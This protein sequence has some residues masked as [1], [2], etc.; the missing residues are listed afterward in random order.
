D[1]TKALERLVAESEQRPPQTAAGAGLSMV[2]RQANGEARGQGEGDDSGSRS[3]VSVDETGGVCGKLDALVERVKGLRKRTAEAALFLTVYDLRRAQEEVDKLWAS[4]ELFRR[5]PR[6]SSSVTS[7][8]SF[9]RCDTSYPRQAFAKQAKGFPHQRAQEQ[10]RPGS[11][12]SLRGLTGEEVDVPAEDADE[13]KDFNVADLDRC[14]VT[15][16]HVLGALRLRRLES[17]RVVCGPVRG[18]IYVEACKDC[19]I[20]A[21]GRQLRI[22]DSEDV[23]FYVLVASGPIIEDCS[24][25]RFAPSGLRYPEY[26]YQLQAAGLAKD[27]VTNAWKDV[28]DFKWHR[29]HK[30]PNWNI[31][32]ETERESD[33]LAVPAPKVDLNAS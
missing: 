14:K 19:V 2:S 17:C 10:G 20:V 29:A 23:D 30:S 31:I 18:P 25:L 21:A 13:D 26:Q 24:R 9:S 11:G 4:A 7:S 8:V 6:T 33:S 32:P 28:K 15:I 3:A 16:L 22:H 12:P 1:I 5:S 27:Q